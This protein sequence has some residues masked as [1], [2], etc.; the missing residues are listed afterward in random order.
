MT[1]ASQKMTL[2]DYLAYDDGTDTRYE[3]V[4]GELV[5]MPPETR[6]NARIA[7]FLVTEFLKHVPFHLVCCKDTEIEVSGRYATA[8][9]PDVMILTEELDQLLG[10]AR[11]TI[12]RD[13][14]PPQL[15]VEVVSPGQEN[16]DRNYR[17]KHSEY[18]ARIA[19]YWIVDPMAEQVMILQWVDG[20]YE[21][22]VFV[23]VD[24]LVSPFLGE[25]GFTVDQL[26]QAGKSS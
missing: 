10:N 24:C 2:D 12:T 6:L 11:G 17:Y 8:R 7:M 25:L 15:V 4:N 23:G 14:P 1:I 3:L 13:M 9:L 19:E 26:M 18:A 22:R 20:L 21:E 16:E 5:P